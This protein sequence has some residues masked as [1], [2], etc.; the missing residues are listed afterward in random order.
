MPP[1]FVAPQPLRSV[2]RPLILP[3]HRPQKLVPKA[4]A[5]Q[6]R[7]AI[8]R[9]SKNPSEAAVYHA[10]HLLRASYATR[11]SA[12]E[13]RLGQLSRDE[14][15]T[16]FAMRY[17]D[18]V[19]R[20]RGA[21]GAAR[22][23]LKAV[24]DGKDGT[25]FLSSVDKTLMR[26]GVG[27][28]GI[29][30]WMAPVV[31]AGAKMRMRDVVGKLV[32]VDGK[33]L[34]EGVEGLQK[35][36]YGVNVNLLGELVLGN[37]EAEARLGK[38]IEMMGNDGIDY[39][40]VKVSGITARLNYWD[41]DGSLKRIETN[42]VRIFRA[43]KQNNTFVN[44]DMEA[45][46]DL[47]L[48]YTAFMSV[49]GRDEFAG[50]D[51]GIVL[52]AYLPDALGILQRLVAW[53]NERYA[54]G[55]GKVKIRIV[56]GANLA[57]EKVDAEL[58]GWEQ[59]PYATKV[60]T[61]ANWLR[62]MDYMIDSDYPERTESVI[63]GVASHN[64]FSVSYVHLRAAENE[65]LDRVQFEMIS[66]MVPAQ[67]AVLR[68]SIPSGM[69]L[70]T[71]VCEEQNFVHA[72]SYLFRRLEENGSGD[73]YLR[74]LMSTD[75]M[76]PGSR[77]FDV[78]ET[79]FKAAVALKDSPDG[80]ATGPRRSQER[81]ALEAFGA[82]RA[83][84]ALSSANPAVDFFVSEP[85]TD[86]AIA[87][88]R[89]WSKSLYY[90][91]QFSPAHT[92]IT[93]TVEGVQAVLETGAKM[94]TE[95]SKVEPKVRAEA[96]LSI[97][98]E[99]AKRRGD[100]I[101]ALIVEGSKLFAEADVEVSE[102]VDF[103]L[104]YAERALHLPS[105][106]KP[107]GTMVVVSPWNYPCA[108][109]AGGV[110][111]SL[112]AGNS[113]ILKPAPETVRCG[114]ILAECIAAANLPEGAFQFVRVPE[115]DCGRHLLTKAD[116]VILTGAS[117]TASLFRSWKPDMKLF[118]ETSGKN[119]MVITPSADMDLAVSDLVE[120]AFGHA[121]QKCSASSLCILVGDMRTDESFFRQL[122]DAVQSLEVG[123]LID[124]LSPLL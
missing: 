24:E 74:S 41:F 46:E 93:A 44:V 27:V 76:L 8:T 86:P 30:P 43:S 53:S 120:S 18:R 7:P 80:L 37:E 89:A 25:A 98:N 109:P 19:E 54:R 2:P 23:L 17:I 87:G 20:V 69:L 42:L 111:S 62:C 63:V 47:S 52:Q 116:G 77:A 107:L 91:S 50:L 96:L 81:P 73:N 102:A 122:K 51:A 1:S 115:N 85:D 97:G 48:S 9:P 110:L 14:R 82:S 16:A 68:D 6:P 112:A 15:A 33:G 34:E 61:D 99:I 75:K 4:V 26:V 84:D 92:E 49:L 113:A 94:A 70:Y 105:T 57:Q 114:E 118:A 40:S 106:F 83:R 88:N 5:Q 65:L 64:M 95:W 90:P 29:A 13:A 22:Q 79:R 71:P 58:R 60:E 32:L 28:L 10:E 66:G 108:I 3:S 101:N 31:M 117:E 12:A 55:G 103:A 11:P 78:E 39:V 35:K 45:Y 59:T 36:G 72:V 121:G 67:S 21:A 119:S 38:A 56:K 104:Y 124:S 100:L 123:M